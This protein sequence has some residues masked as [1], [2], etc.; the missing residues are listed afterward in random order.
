[1]ERNLS[2]AECL[3]SKN[4]FWYF[5]LFTILHALQFYKKNL[6]MNKGNGI[7]NYFKNSTIKY[8]SYKTTIW[9][10]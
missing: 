5:G 2:F 6:W 4:I 8:K 7:G 3:H 10:K 9:C 1:M